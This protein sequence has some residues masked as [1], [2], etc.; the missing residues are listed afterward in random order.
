MHRKLGLSLPTIVLLAAIAAIRAP[1]HDLGTIREGGAAA[2]LPVFAPLAVW[3][4]VV[5]WRRGPNPFPTL[6]AVGLAYGVML[7]V[8]HRLLRG[9]ALGGEPPG[10]G[11][12]LEGVLAPGLGAAFLRVSASFGG[13]VTGTMAGAAAGAVAWAIARLR[14][15]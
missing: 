14:R 15:T 7:A 1:P 9:A 6:T 8:V 2:A 12:D 5:P 10:L 4:G 11:G 13:L 3:A